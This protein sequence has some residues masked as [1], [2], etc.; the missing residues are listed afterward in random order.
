MNK[1]LIILSGL[2]GSGKSHYANLLSGDISVFSTDDFFMRGGAYKYD[3]SLEGKAHAETFRD[4]M[5][6][7]E[8]GIEGPIVVDNTNLSAWEISPY[9]L[10]GSAYGFSAV[11]VRILCD[12]EEAFARQAHGVPREVFDQMV[13]N[14]ANLQ[15][16]A[17]WQVVIN[18]EK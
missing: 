17:H 8:A 18:K 14:F 2:P 7:L 16:P 15:Y 13:E 12:P 4:F 3:P 5:E 9:V 10:A 11:I 6:H 1:K